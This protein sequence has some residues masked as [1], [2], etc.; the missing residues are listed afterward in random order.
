M[1]N[2][3]PLNS[4]QPEF[5]GSDNEDDVQQ[6]WHT[7]IPKKQYLLFPNKMLQKQNREKIEKIRRKESED[8][9]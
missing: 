8:S 4:N 2:K 7:S 5:I 1:I 6:Y 9:K 3:Y